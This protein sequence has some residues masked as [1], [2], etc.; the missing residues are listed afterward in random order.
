MRMALKGNLRVA[1][2][3]SGVLPLGSER[4]QRMNRHRIMVS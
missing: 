1:D 2:K 4:R 3:F